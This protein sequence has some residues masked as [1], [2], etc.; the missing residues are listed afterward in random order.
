MKI[1]KKQTRGK[2]RTKKR[3]WKKKKY[4]ENPEQ[5]KVY[6]KGNILKTL[7]QKRKWKRKISGKSWTKNNMKNKYEES[8]EPKGEYGRSKHEENPETK[9]E[10]EKKIN[11]KES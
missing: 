5:Q 11:M 7:N 4:E 8:L 9:W 1:F 2:F 10:Y 3:I 6:E